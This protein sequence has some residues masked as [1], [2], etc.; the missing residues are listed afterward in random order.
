VDENEWRKL[1]EA[2]TDFAK[3]AGTALGAV[4]FRARFVLS[5][6]QELAPERVR[7]LREALEYA[8]QDADDL[9]AAFGRK[10]DG[11]RPSRREP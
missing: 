11:F 4:L 2:Y 5:V 8:A 6:A 9:F 10:L 1:K 7:G 3:D